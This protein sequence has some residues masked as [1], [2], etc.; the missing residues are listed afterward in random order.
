VLAALRS[1]ARNGRGSYVDLSLF[2]SLVSLM[3][4]HLV[5]TING[6]GPA[7]VPLE[8]AYGLFRTADGK[9][10]GLSVAGEDHFWASLCELTGLR[11]AAT[12]TFAERTTDRERL[13]SRLR[14]SLTKR[15]LAEWTPLLTAAS[16]PFSPVRD[17]AEVADE[18]QVKARRML[19]AAGT[20][21][22]RRT[23]VRQPLQVDGTRPG[24]RGPVPAV[25]EHTREALAAAGYTPKRIESLFATGAAYESR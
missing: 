22:R 9:L 12:L 19:V 25:G 16:V 11:D 8:P 15:T 5:P 23:Y 21:R 13:A 6:T 2:D 14:T 7:Y 24:P 4:V 18:P 1:K 17:L 20:G 3:T 10:L